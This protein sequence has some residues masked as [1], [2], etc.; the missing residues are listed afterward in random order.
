[1]FSSIR[2]G[3]DTSG[4]SKPLDLS[5]IPIVDGTGHEAGSIAPGAVFGVSYPYV[6]KQA[7]YSSVHVNS[8]STDGFQFKNVTARDGNQI[9]IFQA[10]KQPC[11]FDLQFWVRDGDAPGRT[12]NV[13]IQVG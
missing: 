6:G 3:A 4:G 13:P 11:N 9:T 10:P 1:M 7:T 5:K 12:E 8:G 2:F